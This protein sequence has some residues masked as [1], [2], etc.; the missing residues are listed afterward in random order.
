MHGGRSGHLPLV[1]LEVLKLGVV[2]GVQVDRLGLS[3]QPQLRWFSGP[4]T[5]QELRQGKQ[6]L[7]TK[8]N[9]P[10]ANARTQ[11]ARQRA[12]HDHSPA[13]RPTGTS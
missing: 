1:L 6:Q 7:Q 9:L 11:F 5:W 3:T 13:A 2:P 4:S 10:G 12:K 8:Q